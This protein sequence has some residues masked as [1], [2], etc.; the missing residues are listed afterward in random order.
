MSKF[1]QEYKLKEL[2]IIDSIHDNR[3]LSKDDK[4]MLIKMFYAMADFYIDAHINE[5]SKPKA[6]RVVNHISKNVIQFP[7]RK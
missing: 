5:I 3:D 7:Q 4:S 6:S 2:Q 1:Y